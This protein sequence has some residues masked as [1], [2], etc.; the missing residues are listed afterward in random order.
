M[1]TY[2]RTYQL[3]RDDNDRNQTQHY[4]QLQGHYQSNTPQQCH[5]LMASTPHNTDAV[6][7]VK[8]ATPSI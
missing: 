6:I 2:G 7:C 3:Y 5:T 1:F 8:A 4:I